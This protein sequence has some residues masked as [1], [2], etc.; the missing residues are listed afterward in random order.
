V[1][2]VSEPDNACHEMVIVVL[3]VESK[4]KMPGVVGSIP[5]VAET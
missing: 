1:P 4:L 5:V 3:V 2:P